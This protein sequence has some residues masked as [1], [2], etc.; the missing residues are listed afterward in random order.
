MPVIATVLRESIFL[1][2]TKIGELFLLF[3]SVR[4]DL[5]GRT[6]A[7]ALVTGSRTITSDQTVYDNSSSS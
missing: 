2:N 4:A 6:S 3:S 7:L 5:A 1:E